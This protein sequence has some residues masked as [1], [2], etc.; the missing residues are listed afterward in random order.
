LST[1]RYILTIINVTFF[2][3]FNRPS[4][5]KNI[6]NR[7]FPRNMKIKIGIS[8]CLLGQKVRYNGQ[9]KLDKPIVKALGSYVEW[10]PVCPEVECGFSIPREPMRLEGAPAEPRLMTVNSQKDLTEQ[11]LKWVKKRIIE[12]GDE[13]LCGFIFKSKSPSCA[14]MDLIDVYNEGIAKKEGQGIF[15]AAF[16]KHFPLIPVED[17]VQMRITELRDNFIEQAFAYSRFKND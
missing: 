17:E 12:L 4:H 10:V 14:V 5:S 15:A 16:I 2:I 11:M 1:P 8:S 3:K 7:T 9:H 6:K 13:D